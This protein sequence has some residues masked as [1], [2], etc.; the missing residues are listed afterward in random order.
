MSNSWQKAYSELKEYIAGNPKIEIGKNVIAIPGDIRPGFYQIF[1]TVRVDFLKEKFPNLLD[2]AEPL[3]KGY[4]EVEDG[5]T[6]LLGLDDISISASLSWFLHDPTNGLM[7]TLFNLLFDLIKD[8]IDTETFEKEASTIIERAFRDF[9][10]KGYENWVNLSLLELLAAD[11]ALAV[12]TVDYE[13]EDAIAE[14]GRQV[15]LHEESV[16]ELEEMKHLSLTP[17]GM[18]AFIAP[19]IIV[20][21][22]KINRYISTG[23]GLSEASW[24]A[25]LVSEKREWYPATSVKRKLGP[26]VHW[27]DLVIYSDDKPEDLALIA[28]FSRFC[29]PDLIV[30]CMEQKDWYQQEGLERVKLYH[31]VFK[32]RLGTYAVSRE[33]VPEQAFKELLPEQFAEEPAA[34]AVSQEPVSEPEQEAASAE[35]HGERAADIHILAVG[36]D[37][38]QLVPIIEALS[39]GEKG[40]EE[41]GNQ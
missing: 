10:R 8:K 17:R 37:K 4:V 32:P 21:S 14:T 39:P 24:T 27:P 41:S 13:I 31:S 1:D 33:P 11:K 35:E 12:P 22:A 29:R 18:A 23:I 6:K 5:V 40:A 25:K 19:D 20:R 38:S 9:Y 36:F 26:I 2:E 3:S 30:E 28:D 34:E 16:P 15:G 7:R